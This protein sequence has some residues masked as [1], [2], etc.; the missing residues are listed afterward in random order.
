MKF[1]D[2]F[3]V[4]D[5]DWRIC[6]RAV[7]VLDQDNTVRHAEYVPVMGNEVDFITALSTAQKLV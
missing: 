2:D 5:T 3:G 4:H 7:F 1:A 6:Q